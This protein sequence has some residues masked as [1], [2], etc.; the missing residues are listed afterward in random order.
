MQAWR[1]VPGKR[2]Y[3]A[4]IA[5]S[6]PDQQSGWSY[7]YSDLNAAKKQAM[8]RCIAAKGRACEVWVHFE[9]ECGA[10]LLP[11]LAESSLV[12]GQLT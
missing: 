2:W 10:V 11:D 5:Y 1:D 9:N 12:G 8:D 7:D 3:G 4:T 6:V